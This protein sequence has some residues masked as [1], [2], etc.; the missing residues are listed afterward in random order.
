MKFDFR[1]RPRPQRLK[2][3][4]ILLPFSARL[5]AEPFQSVTFIRVVANPAF[6]AL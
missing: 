3:H 2:P 5:K 6:S 4:S 1:M